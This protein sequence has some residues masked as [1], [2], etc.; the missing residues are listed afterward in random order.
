MNLYIDVSS[1]AV[2]QAGALAS[3]YGLEN[4]GLTNLR[5][6]YWNLPAAARA[7]CLPVSTTRGPRLAIWP[8]ERWITSS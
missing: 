2:G 8:S 5:R 3:R 6:V 1:P 7:V 4:H